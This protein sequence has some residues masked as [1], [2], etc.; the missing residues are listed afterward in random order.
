LE[1]GRIA[2]GYSDLAVE[3]AGDWTST[4]RLRVESGSVEELEDLGEVEMG[5]AESLQDV[6]E[7]GLEQ[8]KTVKVALVMWDHGGGWNEFGNDDSHRSELTL[9]EIRDALE[10]GLTAAEREVKLDLIGF[11][12]CLMATYETARE[13]EPFAQYLLASQELEPGNG[14]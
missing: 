6:I 2:D 3:G 9:P 11:D 10:A 7:W 1:D 13:L 8:A 12:A 14:W 5:D 4:K